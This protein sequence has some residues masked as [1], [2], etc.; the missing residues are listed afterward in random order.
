[1]NKVGFHD[2]SQLNLKNISSISLLSIEKADNY[3]TIRD[4]EENSY[5]AVP[6]VIRSTT[7]S[8]LRNTT[9]NSLPHPILLNESAKEN[10]SF[11]ANV[12][13][14]LSSATDTGVVKPVFFVWDRFK[15]QIGSVTQIVQNNVATPTEDYGVYV[16][17]GLFGMAAR[18][19]R[20]RV[21]NILDR[22]PTNW[23]HAL[24]QD[25][26]SVVRNL[27]AI[28]VSRSEQRF[29]MNRRAVSVGNIYDENY[30]SSQSKLGR[31][32]IVRRM[33]SSVRQDLS[34]RLGSGGPSTSEAEFNIFGGRMVAPKE[35]MADS[36]TVATKTNRSKASEFI[37]SASTWFRRMV[38][39]KS[40][41]PLRD[42]SSG[43]VVSQGQS[44]SKAAIAA[45]QDKK[46]S[47][48]SPPQESPNLF[49]SPL[50]GA[51]NDLSGML[52]GA[53]H[54][55]SSIFH[56][57]QLEI[58]RRLQWKA[59]EDSKRNITVTNK[60]V[61][62][63]SFRNLVQAGAEMA[64]FS[65]SRILKTLGVAEETKLLHSAV[66]LLKDDEKR[67][68]WP[69]EVFY[70]AEIPFFE[71]EVRSSSTESE[72]DSR[73]SSTGNIS[74]V[75]PQEIYSDFASWNAA[76]EVIPDINSSNV[77]AQIVTRA[78]TDK[79]ILQRILQRI[80]RMFPVATFIFGSLISI[81]FRPLQRKQPE[82]E[83]APKKQT[84]GRQTDCEIISFVP[85]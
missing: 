52:I 21:L 83:E 81:F 45:R 67:F 73:I 20:R 44:Q 4:Y 29:S 3:S 10:S 19:V 57:V 70:R 49:L 32:A 9:I 34:K 37:K 66:T 35:A 13:S 15:S 56:N 47:S 48:V 26:D 76:E 23:A 28:Y 41:A 61:T 60:D 24:S 68:R 63:E 78:K 40:G 25:G 75:S 50:M 74:D 12:F 22:S 80:F 36:S 55:A 17:K 77:P 65:R 51:V 1:M 39:R 16:P 2:V 18:L 8:E 43:D 82:E 27:P 58:D 69:W 7:A 38:L 54:G 46:L 42:I 31:L 85:G 14:V 59:A 30:D 11:M 64:D 79:H 53:T 6:W 33:L 62:A 84:P 72:E 5:M 71:T